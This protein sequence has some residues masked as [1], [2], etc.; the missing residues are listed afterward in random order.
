LGSTIREIY[1]E[2]AEAYAKNRGLFDMAEVF[3][4]FY[5]RL[6]VKKGRL[7]D[8]GCGAGEPFAGFFVDRGWTV[9]GV[10]FSERMLEL[11]SKYVP[12]MQTIHAD[13][14][15]V[16]FEP[17]QFEAITSIYSL[18]HVPCNDHAALFNKCYQWL[19]PKGKAL[20]TYATK[21][22]TGSIEFD[23]YK[24]FMGRELYYSHKSPDKL[25]ADLERIGFT[26]ESTDYRNIGNEVFLWVTVGKP[27]TEV[28]HSTD[29][30]PTG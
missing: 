5:A 2:F 13:M 11:A 15:E 4:S 23:G 16:E 24:G 9:I 26:V 8:L 12:E 1:D 29:K 19:R 7:L 21:E 28:P 27:I 22:Y 25:Y 6:E 20:F 17:G 14:R 3:D 18:F 30:L 10:D